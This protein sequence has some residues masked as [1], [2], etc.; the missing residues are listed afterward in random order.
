[1]KRM[2]EM[3]GNSEINSGGASAVP[4]GSCRL[5]Q[6][7][8]GVIP[9]PIGSPYQFHAEMAFP[10]PASNPKIQAIL[11]LVAD[12]GMKTGPASED[13]MT[14]AREILITAIASLLALFAATA[15]LLGDTAV[16]PPY[17]SG[18][19]SDSATT[20]PHPWSGNCESPADRSSRA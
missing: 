8:G 3:P 6:I 7:R 2:T 20:L 17:A 1:L 19:C 13:D 5:R 16:A 11:V 10:F 4:A 9:T 14:T 12:G 15:I 18:T